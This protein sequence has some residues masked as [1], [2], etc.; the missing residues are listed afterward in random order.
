MKAGKPPHRGALSAVAAAAGRRRTGRRRRKEG[1]L[2]GVG[3][4]RRIS[5]SPAVVVGG[6]G[7]R[8]EAGECPPW[9][10]DR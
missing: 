9:C 4:G 3:L 10:M 1:R 7:N 6:L 8:K 5:L 2:L